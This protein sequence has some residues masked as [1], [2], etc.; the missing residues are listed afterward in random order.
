VTLACTTHQSSALCRLPHPTSQFLI[1]H[2]MR[3]VVVT[4]L[5]LVTPLGIGAWCQAMIRELVSS[6]P[7]GVRR[8]WKRLLNS[9]SGITSIKN[10]SSEF[11]A[12]PSQ[13]AAVVPEGRKD[14]GMWNAKDWLSPGVG[15]RSRQESR[16]TDQRKDERKMAR[17]AQYAM[18]ASDEAL[19]DAG[20]APQHEDD[21]E[22]TVCGYCHYR[23]VMDL[24]AYR[25]CTWDLVSVVSTIFTIPRLHT[26]R[27]YVILLKE[28]AEINTGKGYKKVSP[29][30]V[31]RLLINLAAGH[32]SMRYGFKVRFS[33]VKRRS[34]THHCRGQIM[35]LPQLARQVRT[36][37]E[38]PRV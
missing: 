15:A 20:W 10:R 8:T 31:P 19:A 12:L 4:G 14:D 30:F 1:R 21:L 34:K 18:V 5:G 24:P 38:T 6:T 33:H 13:V 23:T 17:F 3:R 37:S 29:L 25:V 7:T 2:A 26:Q 36:V 11:A 35:Q 27:V 32:V 16:R 9:E 28:N 22:A